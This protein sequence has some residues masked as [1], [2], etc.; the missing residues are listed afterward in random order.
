MRAKWTTLSRETLGANPY[1]AYCHDRYQLPGGDVGDYYYVSIPGST[2]VVPLLSDGR[3]ILVRQH[4]YLMGRSSVEFPAGGMKQ[5][6]APLRMAQ[7]ELQEEAGYVADRWEEIGQFAPCNGLSNEMCH[8]FVASELSQVDAAPEP[9][10]ELEVLTLTADALTHMVR[11][12][13]IWDGMTI[14]SFGMYE[15][16]LRS[17]GPA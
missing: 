6:Y 3:L 8:V 12:G 7:T 5:G 13:E 1:Y 16:R 9:T 11:M 2:M 4:R 17:H 15:A 14:V 10:E